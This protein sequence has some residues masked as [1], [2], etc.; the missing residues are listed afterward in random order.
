MKN[1]WLAAALNFFFFGAGT[2]YVGR[3]KPAAWALLTL[4]GSAVQVLEIYQ[5]P[6][7]LNWAFWP[8]FFVGL[9][10]MKVALAMDAFQDAKGH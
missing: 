6:P 4:G 1:P 7:F 8:W 5:S 10:A 2:L 3:R 9:A